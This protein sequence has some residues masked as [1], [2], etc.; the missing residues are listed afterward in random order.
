M[1]LNYATRRAD[2]RASFPDKISGENAHLQ[3]PEEFLGGKGPVTSLESLHAFAS[4]DIL[5]SLQR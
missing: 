5:S 1:I 2:Y 4:L 3:Y